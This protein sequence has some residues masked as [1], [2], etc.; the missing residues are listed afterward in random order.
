[1]KKSYTTAGGAARSE[2]SPSPPQYGS[3]YAEGAGAAAGTSMFKQISSDISAKLLASSREDMA[4]RRGG[5][6]AAAAGNLLFD[7]ISS[8]ISAKLLAS[9]REDMASRTKVRGA[10]ERGGRGT[11]AGPPASRTAATTRQQGGFDSA[12]Q[13]RFGETN[14]L[15]S[16]NSTSDYNASVYGSMSESSDQSQYSTW[17]PQGGTAAAAGNLLFDRISRDTSEKVLASSREDM[18]SRRGG[19]IAG[20]AA[21]EG[22]ELYAPSQQGSRTANS[23]VSSTRS[24]NHAGVFGL[25]G[26]YDSHQPN[27]P[28]QSPAGAAQWTR[29]DSHMLHSHTSSRIGGGQEAGAPASRTAGEQASRRNR[30]TDSDDLQKL[31]S[32]VSKG[33]LE[34]IKILLDKGI[35]INAKDLRGYT[36]LH[37]ATNEGS[38][39]VVKFLIEMGAN[40]DVKNIK[41]CTALH[42]A[43]NNGSLATLKCLIEL[44]ADVN[45]KNTEDY[46]ALHFAAY[47]NFDHVVLFLIKMGADVSVQNKNGDTALDMANRGAERRTT[48]R[49]QG[50][51][52]SSSQQSQRAEQGTGYNTNSL[53]SHSSSRIGGTATGGRGEEASRSGAAEA[54]STSNNIDAARAESSTRPQSMEAPSS[55]RQVGTATRTRHQGEFGSSSQQSQRAE[56]GTGYDTQSLRS[57]SSSPTGGTAAGARE[58][59][60]AAAREGGELY[61]PS[62]QGSR[63]ANSLVSSTRSDNHAGVFGLM[64]EYDSH[65]PNSPWQSP[66][67]AAQWTRD[68]SHMLHSHTSSRIGGGQ[69]A[70]APASRTAGEQ[71]SRRNRSTDSDDLQ[72]LF[73][74]VSKGDLQ[75]IKRLNDKGIDLNAKNEQGY[76][77]LHIATNE[78]SLAT[79]KHLIELGADVNAKDDLRGCTA[80]QLA[81]YLNF[82]HVVKF[83]IKMGADVNAKNKQGYTALQLAKT[84]K[85]SEIIDI[86]EAER[87]VDANELNILETKYKGTDEIHNTLDYALIS[88]TQDISTSPLENASNPYESFIN[89]YSKSKDS[90]TALDTALELFK[91]D[92]DVLSPSLIASS[93]TLNGYDAEIHSHLLLHALYSSNNQEISEIR[94]AFYEEKIANLES[95][96]ANLQDEESPARFTSTIA[97][98]TK[99][100]EEIEESL[101]AGEGTK[102][103]E[104]EKALRFLVRSKNAPQAMSFYLALSKAVGN[105]SAEENGQENEKLNKLNQAFAEEIVKQGYYFYYKFTAT[106]RFTGN[107]KLKGAIAKASIKYG[108]F[109]ILHNL[110][111]L[112]P[113]DLHI[114]KKTSDNTMPLSREAIKAEKLKDYNEL[115]IARLKVCKR[116]ALHYAQNQIGD[117]DHSKRIEE[118]ALKLESSINKLEQSLAPENRAGSAAITN[119]DTAKEALDKEIGKALKS[120]ASLIYLLANENTPL[121]TKLMHGKSIGGKFG[122][123]ITTS[124]GSK[125]A[126]ERLIEDRNTKLE[127]LKEATKSVKKDEMELILT[128]LNSAF[129]DIST[130][131]TLLSQF[132][133]LATQATF[134]MVP[135]NHPLKKEI[136]DAFLE[137][138]TVE[139]VATKYQNFVKLYKDEFSIFYDELKADIIEFSKTR[140]GQ[141]EDILDKLLQIRKNYRIEL[142]I[143]E[144][145]LG[146]NGSDKIRNQL[147]KDG[148]ISYKIPNLKEIRNMNIKEF[149]S[150]VGKGD[151]TETA[152]YFI[153]TL[154]N[155]RNIKAGLYS[156]EEQDKAG[157][158]LLHLAVKLDDLGLIKYLERHSRGRFNEYLNKEDKKG[159][160]PLAYALYKGND[161]ISNYL[162]DKMKDRRM[163][164]DTDIKKAYDS[165]TSI[166]TH[167]P[168]KGHYGYSESPAI[169]YATSPLGLVSANTKHLLEKTEKVEKIKQTA[170]LRNYAKEQGD[171]VNTP[172]KFYGLESLEKAS[173]KDS[174]PVR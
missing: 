46:T 22:G 18:A 87:R 139:D 52:G 124:E 111:E 7:R 161:E 136:Y 26:E 56:Q 146:E 83:L 16:D 33:K 156:Q 171:D 38:L 8:D 32:A 113:I 39:E 142:D 109:A 51:F 105:G 69:E 11:E 97:T 50:G 28:W 29:D 166:F 167:K 135:Q 169:Q 88:K 60:G 144:S 68:D 159:M 30:S 47:L 114:V 153:K 84:K 42:I 131:K 143:K 163:D 137:N 74:A 35:D 73:S 172:G 43:A 120:Q 77:A 89:L 48:T 72:K 98:Y 19:G 140:D 128:K 6:I 102:P 145:D 4:S 65:Q 61:A 66:A 155:F 99:K 107:E 80:L 126:L 94:K 34:E 2:E 141:C 121:D 129:P 118:K 63:T 170:L 41:G 49:H 53:R 67:G 21:R 59:G 57:H 147:R 123:I 55:V 134:N 119:P 150:K 62:Q 168:P 122:S 5:G 106:E 54:G 108:E 157:R 127:A 15:F 104:L 101:L 78:G 151:H 125:D 138:A 100:L 160:S 154:D 44:G 116:T 64:G 14:S 17:Q 133:R 91:N 79:V 45:A 173:K 93:E 164:T 37:I 165:L 40:V 75:E 132:Y 148:V 23:L 112:E 82:D 117:R 20:A 86:L 110:T 81:A 71:A 1:M 3:I 162:N 70:G 158:N 13:H 152:K 85:H 149:S 25:M 95:R 24:D 174:S 9:S 96:I 90:Q 92:D 10:R 103:A 36:A 130:D 12:S 27:S 58:G 31:F 76:T 115:T